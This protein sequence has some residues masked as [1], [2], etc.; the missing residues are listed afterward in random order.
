MGS[1][2]KN[3][4]RTLKI[5][6]ITCTYLEFFPSIGQKSADDMHVYWTIA[7]KYTIWK[8][9]LSMAKVQ[10]KAFDNFFL[11][12]IDKK[13]ESLQKQE[14]SRIVETSTFACIGNF[15]KRCKCKSSPRNSCSFFLC[16]SHFDGCRTFCRRGFDRLA[17]LIAVDVLES[18]LGQWHTHRRQ[19]PDL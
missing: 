8:H 7:K 5:S 9:K 3:Y 10:S 16:R 17:P 4:P 6:W 13:L 2:L 12:M 15:Q 19:I 11:T 14:I 1:V 18:W